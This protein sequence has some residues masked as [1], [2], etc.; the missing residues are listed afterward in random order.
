MRKIKFDINKIKRRTARRNK[1]RKTCAIS[2]F[3]VVIMTVLS[4]T[5]YA[6]NNKKSGRMEYARVVDTGIAVSIDGSSEYD[7][8]CSYLNDD[9]L[10]VVHRNDGTDFI[11]S[12]Y[13][14]VRSGDTLWDI[15]TTITANEFDVRDYV[16]EIKK[17]NNIKGD[18]VSN[19]IIELPII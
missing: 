12:K 7:I 4:I 3:M 16:H 11:C 15:A 1:I 10:L 2:L 9:E 17:L 19:T 5:V 18:I 14:Y 8:S 13:Y 6:V